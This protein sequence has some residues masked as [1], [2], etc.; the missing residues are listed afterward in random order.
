MV[1]YSSTY[2]QRVPQGIGQV[3]RKKRKAASG[4]QIKPKILRR[5]LLGAVALTLMIGL[6]SML[7]GV[8]LG[9]LEGTSWSELKKIEVVGIER[10]SE[11]S[12]IASADVLMGSNLMRLALDSVAMR[13]TALPAV[14]QAR[15]IRRLPGKL[16]IVIEERSPIAIVIADEPKLVDKDG[17]LF[18]VIGNGEII[19]MPLLTGL[20]INS[21]ALSLIVKYYDDFPCLYDNISEINSDADQVTVRL[22]CG[23]AVVKID[24]MND[25]ELLHV[26]ESFLVQHGEQLSSDLTYVDLRHSGMVVTG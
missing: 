12:M 14:K 1:D 17:I 18:P 3:T 6:L 24:D 15:V 13:L 2:S 16:Q 23:S 20:K 8:M 9:W 7:W 21:T 26:L 19:D 11:G 22:R 4:T 10:L 25:V 5:T